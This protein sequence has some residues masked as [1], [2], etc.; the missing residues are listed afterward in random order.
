[1][2]VREEISPRWTS[3]R[4][5]SPHF[6]GIQLLPPLRLRLLSSCVGMWRRVV[7]NNPLLAPTWDPI[8][9]RM[10]REMISHKAGERE[11]EHD[12]DDDA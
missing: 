8:K 7:S 11:R 1:M 10:L 4:G 5:S 2:P 12:D 3:R 9:R 6:K